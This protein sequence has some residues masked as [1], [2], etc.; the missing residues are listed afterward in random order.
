M[1]RQVNKEYREILWRVKLFF[2]L[3]L[4][5]GF[6]GMVAWVWQ[7]LGGAGDVANVARVVWLSRGDWRFWVVVAGFATLGGWLAFVLTRS[8]V[9]QGGEQEQGGGMSGPRF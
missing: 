5:G 2:G 3:V 9:E 1:M 8:R 7:D 6:L 4:L